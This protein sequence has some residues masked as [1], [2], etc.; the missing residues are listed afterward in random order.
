MLKLK[1]HTPVL[2][3]FPCGSGK[4][5]AYNEGDLDSIPGLGRPPGEGKVYPLQYS[6]L[7]NEGSVVVVRWLQSTGSVAVAHRLCC[8]EV[9][10]GG[11][12]SRTRVPG[13]PSPHTTTEGGGKGLRREA[14][15]QAS[16]H[17]SEAA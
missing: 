13:H 17:R 5:S 15:R 1:L 14:G 8:P 16:G 2:L 3:G 9:P 6:G 12:P 4:E 10:R 7:K 11:G